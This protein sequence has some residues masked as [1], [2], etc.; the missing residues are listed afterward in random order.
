MMQYYA[1]LA[2][3]SAI[4]YIISEKIFYTTIITTVQ[5]FSKP[6]ASKIKLDQIPMINIDMELSNI[7]IILTTRFIGLRYGLFIV[8]LTFLIHLVHVE[9]ISVRRI[10]DYSLRG[11]SLVF[12]V[13]IFSSISIIELTPYLILAIKATMIM[14]SSILFKA[15]VL[16]YS[17][18][19]EAFAIGYYFVIFEI[20]SGIAS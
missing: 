10:L 6:I 8:G 9:V 7:L 1:L 17:N 13:Y 20:I 18:L 12:G 16:S 15:S 4:L 11:A 5:Y 14:F 19:K 3:I 2:L